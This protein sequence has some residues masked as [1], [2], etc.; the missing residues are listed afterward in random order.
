LARGNA[1][2]GTKAL[3]GKPRHRRFPFVVHGLRA[4]H[5]VQKVSLYAVSFGGSTHDPCEIGL[6]LRAIAHLQKS[7]ATFE[8]RCVRSRIVGL[9]S[10]H[11]R[12][13]KDS[14]AVRVAVAGDDALGGY[15]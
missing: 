8:D 5:R 3:R 6:D 12:D 1:H 15:D 14:R 13:R 2:T 4:T 7:Y 10:S 11:T 9:A